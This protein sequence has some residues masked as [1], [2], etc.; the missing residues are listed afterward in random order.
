ML[1]L[2]IVIIILIAVIY[3]II[4][5]SN[6]NTKTKTKIQKLNECPDVFS[7]QCDINPC[8]C[9]NQRN[10]PKYQKTVNINGID[11][12]CF[13][14]GKQCVTELNEPNN[15]EIINTNQEYLVNDIILNSDN[16]LS[17]VPE[18]EYLDGEISNCVCKY[19][20]QPVQKNI[21]TQNNNGNFIDNIGYICGGNI[22]GS[23][24]YAD[25][26]ITANTLIEMTNDRVINLEPKRYKTFIPSVRDPLIE[27]TYKNKVQD[28]IDKL[29]G[30]VY[31][32]P[33]PATL[34]KTIYQ[35]SGICPQTQVAPY[36][37]KKTNKMVLN[38]N[39]LW[40]PRL[41]HLANERE[42]SC[43]IDKVCSCP[44]ND[45]TKW[46]IFM[47]DGSHR[48]CI[49]CGK[50][51]CPN[52]EDASIEI[53]NDGDISAL[54]SCTEIM[55]NG[56]NSSNINQCKCENGRTLKRSLRDFNGKQYSCDTCENIINACPANITLN[57]S[58]GDRCSTDPSCQCPRDSDGRLLDKY[59]VV[60]YGKG[61]TLGPNPKYNSCY[62]CGYPINSM[63]YKL[64]VDNLPA[65]NTCLLSNKLQILLSDI[66]SEIKKDKHSFDQI[67]DDI[68]NRVLLYND[69]THIE[70][71]SELESLPDN[72]LQR[73]TIGE[74]FADIILKLP[75]IYIATGVELAK[76]ENCLDIAN[77]SS[78]ID[79]GDGVNCRYNIDT[80]E[81]YTIMGKLTHSENYDYSRNNNEEN[82][83][84]L[85]NI[86]RYFSN[87]LLDFNYSLRY[88]PQTCASDYKKSYD[89]YP[90]SFD[91][92][93][94]ECK[95]LASRYCPFSNGDKIKDSF[96]FR[97]N[98]YCNKNTDD[99]CNALSYIKNMNDDYI[100][101]RVKRYCPNS[102][103][104]CEENAVT[105]ARDHI[106]DINNDNDGDVMSQQNEDEII[107][108]YVNESKK[109]RTQINTGLDVLTSRSGFTKYVDDL[110]FN[111]LDMVN[112]WEFKYK[113]ANDVEFE[114][115][116]RIDDADM[117]NPVS[118][119]LETADCYLYDSISK[120]EP[121]Y[122][123]DKNEILNGIYGYCKSPEKS[124][125]MK[126]IMEKCAK[127]AFDEESPICS[128]VDDSNSFPFKLDGVADCFGKYDLE[129]PD[130]I[131]RCINTKLGDACIGEVRSLQ[132][133]YDS[134]CRQGFNKCVQNNVCGTRIKTSSGYDLDYT[135]IDDS[136][137]DNKLCNTC[138]D[139][140]YDCAVRNQWNDK[141]D[142]KYPPAATPKT[143]H[144][145][146]VDN[147]PDKKNT[148]C[149]PPK[150]GSLDFSFWVDNDKIVPERENEFKW[151]INNWWKGHPDQN[152]DC[153][154]KWVLKYN[155]KLCD[156]NTCNL[157]NM[158]FHIT[159]SND[160]TKSIAIKHLL[161]RHLNTA[162]NE[163][164]Y[165]HTV[166]SYN[167][168]NAL[169]SKILWA[170]KYKADP[171]PEC[172]TFYEKYLFNEIVVLLNKFNVEDRFKSGI[173]LN[174]R[175]QLENYLI[176]MK[177]LKPYVKYC[178][179]KGRAYSTGDTKISSIDLNYL[180]SS[181]KYLFFDSSNVNGMYNLL[182]PLDVKTS[183]TLVDGSIATFKVDFENITLDVA[184]KIKSIFNTQN[185]QKFDPLNGDL[186]I[187]YL[188]NVFG[189]YN[190]STFKTVFKDLLTDT[191]KNN[192][193]ISLNN[194]IFLGG[195]SGF[196]SSNYIW[197]YEKEDATQRQDC[198]NAMTNGY[199]GDFTGL[200]IDIL[201]GGTYSGMTSCDA[202]TPLFFHKNTC[203]LQQLVSEK[204]VQC[205]DYI[206]DLEK[207]MSDFSDDNIT[208]LCL[209]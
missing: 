155:N 142:I 86:I 69:K 44:Y 151:Y 125:W 124:L 202:D 145:Y 105:R 47:G 78:E 129:D 55:Y 183:V 111:I 191:Q 190:G 100:N 87:D 192:T 139:D 116:C 88:C 6:T 154:G 127:S 171:N 67:S 42:I 180:F 92:F 150:S 166:G 188:F 94:D 53:V 65:S 95:N 96:A 8:N 63:I 28:T 39:F 72:C 141:K 209:N 48:D 73:N 117:L 131:L 135:K 178:Y 51:I 123:T 54:F 158:S 197:L 34:Q 89:F 79:T 195:L 204:K 119:F 153:K 21:I 163:Y 122:R 58:D 138:V 146:N 173:P 176:K 206:I 17:Y 161:A 126:S 104:K 83:Q 2:L 26:D 25:Y 132:K 27:Q 41:T 33:D 177:N 99:N 9:P 77:M 29:S 185:L 193:M 91:K 32:K 118:N 35:H 172:G 186:F 68:L 49:T 148:L 10:K 16:T 164:I 66:D 43:G 101:G 36:K 5:K 156:T 93:P 31:V 179:K 121:E 169:L 168:V 45:E 130:S 85:S 22:D 205:S 11:K 194:D 74:L 19:D 70:Y 38:D 189:V 181:R 200:N 13:Y 159:I 184:E 140:A 98:E 144:L 103:W 37:S 113:L 114:D 167:H 52:E 157:T 1:L 134:L 109:L 187:N 199:I 15:I 81:I 106:I 4:N 64:C 7:L 149:I 82:T 182:N 59:E 60:D 107:A 102:C 18:Y 147:C 108:F 30:T 207:T 160:I 46:K 162:I 120:I 57:T 133:N 84:R 165:Q 175:L 75:I 50:L 198:Y 97:V 110:K 20:N 90:T 56:E 80:D 196:T 112:K 152:T 208:K 201:P 128:E 40:D 143:S 61:K 23:R 203:N 14:C 137:K 3:F 136:L 115:K 12:N 76:K 174:Y 24:Q 170:T 71:D 62:M